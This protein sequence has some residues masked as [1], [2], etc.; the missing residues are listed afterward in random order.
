MQQNNRLKFELD[1]VPLPVTRFVFSQSLDH[2]S[3]CFEAAIPGDYAKDI[4]AKIGKS[5]RIKF[6]G[7]ERE[8]ILDAVSL[9]LPSE[10]VLSGRDKTSLLVDSSAEVLNFAGEQIFFSILKKLCKPYGISVL[11]PEN[12]AQF[13]V[14]NFS[15]NPG[16]SVFESVSEAA[17]KGGVFLSSDDGS[18]VVVKSAK[19]KN[20]TYTINDASPVVEFSFSKNTSEIYGK[21][22]GLVKNREKKN[23]TN[24]HN[25]SAW[26]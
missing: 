21:Y 26:P 4:F 2:L 25:G 19:H 6:G 10:L 18:S 5:V 12:V 3:G 11:D 23:E 24:S 13:K 14:K 22:I 7:V 1:G 16:D 8:S 15:V 20:P 9:R 17:Q